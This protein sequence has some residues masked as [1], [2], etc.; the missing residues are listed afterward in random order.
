VSV[1]NLMGQT[2]DIFHPQSQKDG[3]GDLRHLW[4]DTPDETVPCRLQ[5]V[6]TSSSH[7]TKDHDERDLTGSRWKLYFMPPTTGISSYDRVRIDGKMFELG[8]L[9]PV[10]HPHRGVDHYVAQLT[11]VNNTVNYAG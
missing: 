2:V 10:E 8:G 6:I 11:T 5:A 4:S 7:G 9:Y 3:F 1:V